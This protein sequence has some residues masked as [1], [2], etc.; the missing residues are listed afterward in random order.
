MPSDHMNSKLSPRLEKWV[1]FDECMA[2]LRAGFACNFHH[3][4]EDFPIQAVILDLLMEA[5]V[6]MRWFL[7]IDC[8]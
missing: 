7:M 8:N 1:N 3:A 6:E 4:D 2:V 5:K